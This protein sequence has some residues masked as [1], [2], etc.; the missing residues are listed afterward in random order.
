MRIET[1]EDFMKMAL[2]TAMAIEMSPII[3]ESMLAVYD[4]ALEIETKHGHKT[5]V[6][7]MKENTVNFLT[8]ASNHAPMPTP[9]EFEPEIIGK[10]YGAWLWCLNMVEMVEDKHEVLAAMSELN[11]MFD[12]IQ[13]REF[14]ENN[15]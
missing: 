1:E 11:G 4:L 14:Q 8:D 3:K 7:N 5:T 12:K 2:A 13:K 10:C 9:Q 6:E 15:R